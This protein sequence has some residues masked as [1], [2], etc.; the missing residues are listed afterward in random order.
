[1][2][3]SQ[4]QKKDI[5]SGVKYLESPLSIPIPRIHLLRFHRMAHIFENAHII[6][7]C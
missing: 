2:G 3:L 4:I 1:M 5:N 7:S 6:F